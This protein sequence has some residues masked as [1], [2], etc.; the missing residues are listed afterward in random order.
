MAIGGVSVAVATA[1]KAWACPSYV[2]LRCQHFTDFCKAALCRAV[3]WHSARVRPVLGTGRRLRVVVQVN[4]KESQRQLPT[5]YRSLPSSGLQHCTLSRS[6]GSD[7]CFLAARYDQVWPWLRSPFCS[8]HE[9]NDV[10]AC[11]ANNG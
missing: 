11:I 3:S 8:A 6:S 5:I 2:R 1:L 4:G 10:S 7:N 9:I